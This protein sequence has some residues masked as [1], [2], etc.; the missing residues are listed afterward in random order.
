MTPP[1]WH[2]LRSGGENR[3]HSATS[4]TSGDWRGFNKKRI[5]TREA[6]RENGVAESWRAVQTRLNSIE[7]GFT[8]TRGE[9]SCSFKGSDPIR[10]CERQVSEAVPR[11]TPPSRD[12]Q[13]RPPGKKWQNRKNAGMENAHQ[14]NFTSP[15]Q[16]NISEQRIQGINLNFRVQPLQSTRWDLHMLSY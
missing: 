14:N 3:T 13:P 2:L 15:H 16:L 1:Q 4:D 7:A 8:A 11:Q 10:S 9:T 12:G 6:K 5:Q